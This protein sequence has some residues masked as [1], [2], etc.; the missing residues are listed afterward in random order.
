MQGNFLLF[1]DDNHPGDF[2]SVSSTEEGGGAIP[3]KG[4]EVTKSARQLASG[5]FS[6]RAASKFPYVTWLDVEQQ[7]LTLL[8]L[9]SVN[10][11]RLSIMR[12][13]EYVSIYPSRA[14]FGVLRNTT[15]CYSIELGLKLEILFLL[16]RRHFDKHFKRWNPHPRLEPA[17]F[18][19]IL[20]LIVYKLNFPLL[21][22]SAPHITLY[23]PGQVV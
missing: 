1:F 16:M 8:D 20:H 7:R 14:I 4:G 21:T 11:Q 13:A 5:L 9:S 3:K 22:V 17:R 12:R 6:R 19:L 23:V 18:V 10:N 2:V 15:M